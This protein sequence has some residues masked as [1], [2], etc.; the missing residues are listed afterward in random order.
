MVQPYLLI[1]PMNLVVKVVKCMSLA[2]RS[3]VW[4]NSVWTLYSRHE[5][6]YVHGRLWHNRSSWLKAVVMMMMTMMIMMMM[7]SWIASADV[8]FSVAYV[9]FVS[10]ASL[11]RGI[12][13][14]VVM[15]H[16]GHPLC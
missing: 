9:E 13:L 8:L 5:D 12:L 2:L 3:I 10:V 6:C 14:A 15:L 1:H 7:V 4:H 16:G 11:L